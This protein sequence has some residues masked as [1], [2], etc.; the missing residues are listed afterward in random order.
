MGR[1]AAL[2]F[3]VLALGGC[4]NG[5]RDFSEPMRARFLDACRTSGGEEGECE[6][7]LENVE[8]KMTEE[9]YTD[10]ESQGVDSVHDDEFR[11]ALNA[12]EG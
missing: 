8:E 1:A 7:V 2:L 5:S 12:C 6:C 11:E 4:D 10:L 9:E 3:V